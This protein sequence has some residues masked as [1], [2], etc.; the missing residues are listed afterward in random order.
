MRAWV[1]LCVLRRLVIDKKSFI[2]VNLVCI[3]FNQIYMNRNFFSF[4]SMIMIVLVQSGCVPNQ[5]LST[6][7]EER[8]LQRKVDAL[9]LAIS[10]ARAQRNFVRVR[11]LS[12]EKQRY[13]VRIRSIRSYRIQKTNSFLTPYSGMTQYNDFTAV[14]PS[15]PTYYESKKQAQIEADAALARKLQADEFRRARERQAQIEA[16][17]ELARRLQAEECRR[18]AER[19]AQD[20]ARRAQIEADAELARRLQEEECRKAAERQAQDDA[21]RA[22]IEADRVLAE[23]LQKQE[24]QQN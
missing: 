24:D 17:A 3:V 10:R 8:E 11:T 20:D 4:V 22:Q 15:K 1:V 21:R 9:T 6:D 12:E 7:Y 13:I 2:F 23:Q 16:D 19:Q 18:A 14:H 5:S